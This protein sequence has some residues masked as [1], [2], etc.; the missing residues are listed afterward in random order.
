LESKEI[1]DASNAGERPLLLGEKFYR[2]GNKNEDYVTGG[3]GYTLNKAA[4][5]TLVSSFPT[6]APHDITSA[7]DYLVT[8]CLKEQGVKAY[9]TTD[10]EGADR[11]NHVHPEIDFNFDPKKNPLFW[12]TYFSANQNVGPARVARRSVSFHLKGGDVFGR[13]RAGYSMRRIHSIL[14][15]HCANVTIGPP[16]PTK[17]WNNGEILFKY[18]KSPKKACE[19]KAKAGEICICSERLVRKQAIVTCNTKKVEIEGELDYVNLSK[20]I[21]ILQQSHDE[22]TQ[23]MK[24]TEAI[25]NAVL[26]N[27]KQMKSRIETIL[28]HTERNEIS[29]LPTEKRKASISSAA[30]LL[31]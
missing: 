19:L 20:T 30:A 15:G 4:L 1:L 3:G 21:S 31:P 10:E 16:V 11:Y 14:Y 17:R 13:P 24:Q 9:W 7:E 25:L 29:Q 22:L 6:C 26:N 5:K 12:Y 28:H 2:D 27:Q 8:H 23:K 18:W